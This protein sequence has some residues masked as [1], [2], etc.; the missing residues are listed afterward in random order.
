MSAYYVHDANG[1]P[2]TYP[3]PCPLSHHAEPGWYWQTYDVGRIGPFPDEESAIKAAGS[4][5]H[6]QQE[7]ERLRAEQISGGKY[8]LPPGYTWA[9]V[10]SERVQYGI[11]ERHFPQAVA[12]GCVGWGTP[13]PEWCQDP[14]DA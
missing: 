5:M 8:R 10:A 13:L 1:R 12:P 14:A 6:K 3:S 2:I 11:R 4:Q 9:R 7:A